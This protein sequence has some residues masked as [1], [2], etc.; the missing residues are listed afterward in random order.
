MKRFDSWVNSEGNSDFMNIEVLKNL[1]NSYCEQF[2]VQSKCIR[3]H[4]VCPTSDIVDNFIDDGFIFISEINENGVPIYNVYE[5]S[6]GNIEQI[7]PI[8]GHS[9]SACLDLF[10]TS[11]IYQC[12]CPEDC[13]L[14]GQAY[15]V[16]A[17]ED[18]EPLIK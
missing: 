6:L 17:I 15:S 13:V 4:G 7:P 12:D 11:C 2:E 1:V 18:G 5:I 16:H 8:Y 10:I 3:V 14:L 9:F